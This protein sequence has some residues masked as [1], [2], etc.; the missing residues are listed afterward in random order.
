MFLLGSMAI[1]RGFHFHEIFVVF[2]HFTVMRFCPHHYSC[3]ST[4]VHTIEYYKYYFYSLSVLQN[5]KH[6]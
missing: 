5:M 2:G 4:P 3:L 6:L 1:S